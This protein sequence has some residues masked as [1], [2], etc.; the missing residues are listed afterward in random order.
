MM[1]SNADIDLLM[2]HCIE[3]RTDYL[4]LNN[5]CCILYKSMLLSCALE[6]IK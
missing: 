2:T 6:H 3:A 4:L 1:N 5:L